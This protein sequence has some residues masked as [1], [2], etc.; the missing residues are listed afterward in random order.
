MLFSVLIWAVAVVL[1]AQGKKRR[2]ANLPNG[3]AHQEGQNRTEPIFRWY[4]VFRGI[5]RIDWSLSEH[6]F[7][8]HVKISREQKI[9]QVS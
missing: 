1:I 9:V 2:V 3:S 7:V 6:D 5:E 4:F 8:S